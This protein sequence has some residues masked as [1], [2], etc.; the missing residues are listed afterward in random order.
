VASKGAPGSPPPRD[1][2][3]AGDGRTTQI[4]VPL[5]GL[6]VGLGPGKPQWRPTADWLSLAP[7]SWQPGPCSIQPPST[8]REVRV[9]ALLCLART[10][11]IGYDSP[12]GIFH[13]QGGRCVI[14]DIY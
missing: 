9:T 6:G 13:K 12:E 7:G 4:G 11:H 3:A 14:R 5:W 2:G 10:D 1:E 8:C